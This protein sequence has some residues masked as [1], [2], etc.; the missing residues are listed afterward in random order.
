MNSLMQSRRLFVVLQLAV[1]LGMAARL[2]AADKQG[3]DAAKSEKKIDLKGLTLTVPAAWQRKESKSRFRPAEF[4]IPPVDGDHEP[5]EFTVFLFGGREGGDADANI[6]RWIGQVEAKGRKATVWSGKGKAGKYQIVDVTGN[7]KK[8]IG[9]PIQQQFEVKK[10]W[11]V[12]NVRLE[13]E[14]DLFFLKLAG[15]EKTVTAAADAFRTA[16][17]ADASSE[18]ELPQESKKKD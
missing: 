4:E 9:P 1:V 15:P 6:K 5:A 7:Y 18:R 11:R 8:S 13:G 17:G 10:G 12:I 2:T 14:T 16:W 3:G